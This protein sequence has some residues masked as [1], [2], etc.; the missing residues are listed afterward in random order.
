[1]PG[2]DVGFLSKGVGGMNGG[3]G[4]ECTPRHSDSTTF[5]DWYSTHSVMV[6]IEGSGM[7]RYRLSKYYTFSTNTA[8]IYCYICS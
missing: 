8:W 6:G 4:S 5:V 1:M 7:Q 3:M 2:A